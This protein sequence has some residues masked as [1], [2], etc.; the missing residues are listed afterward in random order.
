MKPIRSLSFLIVV[1]LAAAAQAA[2]PSFTFNVPHKVGVGQMEIAVA[3][4]TVSVTS[5]AAVTFRISHAGGSG[6]LANV[7]T[8]ALT[9]NQVSNCF[10]GGNCFALYPNNDILAVS[11]PSTNGKPPGDPERR[12]Y[13]F[14]FNLNGNI[15]RNNNCVS[16]LTASE[17]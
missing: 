2:V 14:F 3:K 1:A 15:D 9:P 11:P 12:K 4:V 16:L 8:N 10:S 17:Q 7:D 6:P 5:E 13:T